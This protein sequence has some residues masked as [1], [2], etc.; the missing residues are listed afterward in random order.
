MIGVID[1]V[2]RRAKMPYWLSFG[3]LYGLIGNGGV[4]PDGYFDIWRARARITALTIAHLKESL[5]A[6]DSGSRKG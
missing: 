6:T 4:V 5:N 2:F 3:A 1:D